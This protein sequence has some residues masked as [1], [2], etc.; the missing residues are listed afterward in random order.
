MLLEIEGLTVK[1]GDIT[2]LHNISSR[3]ETRQLTTLL[4]ANG[5]GKSTLLNAIFGL[6][7]PATG[8]SASRAGPLTA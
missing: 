5:A 2:A 1:Y 8:K 3:G 7:K 4:G 6:L